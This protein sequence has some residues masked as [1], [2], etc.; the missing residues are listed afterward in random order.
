MA[1]CLCPAQE[2]DGAQIM[3]FLVGAG[4]LYVPGTQRFT[5]GEI[6]AAGDRAVLE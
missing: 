3:E 6:T 2:A 5:F 1:I 4:E